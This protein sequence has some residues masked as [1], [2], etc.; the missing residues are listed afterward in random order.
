MSQSTKECHIIGWLLLLSLSGCGGSGCDITGKVLID[1]QPF[2]NGRIA[3]RPVEKAPRSRTV[4]AVITDGEF[5]FL[6]AQKVLPGKYEVVIT[7]RRATGQQLPPEEGTTE[8]MPRYEQYLPA[9]YNT[10]TEL[11][12]EI[13]DRKSVLDFELEMPK[14]RGTRR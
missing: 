7:A 9:K 8:V 12:A 1:G 13:T 3:L 10:A 11:L 5:H 4:Q 2:S 6:P 14:T